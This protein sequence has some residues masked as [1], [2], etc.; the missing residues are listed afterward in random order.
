MLATYLLK[1]IFVRKYLIAGCFL[2]GLTLAA[3]YLLVT[4]PVYRS[5][6]SVVAGVRPPETIGP[7]S[8]AEQLSADYLLTQEDI[9]KSDRVAQEVVKSTRLA[10]APNIAERF[11]WS[12]EFGPLTD[13]I[14]ERLRLGLIVEQ[15]TTNSRVMNVS[16]LSGDPEFSATMANAFAD[17]FIQTNLQL[18]NDPARRNIQS[19]DSQLQNIAIK[20]KAMQAELAKKEKA[21]GIV[22]SKGE[23]DPG[24]TQLSALASN[25]ASAEAN[26]ANAQ[27]A[28]RTGAL[29]SEVSNPVVQDLQV[30]I[31]SKS[32]QLSQLATTLGPN[33]PDYRQV[34]SELATLKS[35]LALQ[36][37][38]VRR[39]TAAAA[40]QATQARGQIAGAVQSQRSQVTATRAAQNE[41]AVL[42][43][44]LANLRASYDQIGQRRAQLEVLD[45]TDQTNISFLSRAVP[46]PEPVAPKETLV[47]L[48]GALG[49]LVL[50]LAIALAHEFSNRRIR[51]SEQLESQL[52]IRD[53]G[54]IRSNV[55]ERISTVRMATAL[56]SAPRKLLSHSQ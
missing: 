56:L 21:L 26:A 48:L 3:I 8:V 32:G 45:H 5:T 24:V 27:A 23:A 44:D 19:Y 17:A 55:G 35:Q 50:G 38:I 52:G 7:L 6:A 37:S 20:M 33:H 43:Q 40:A 11:E 51:L 49:G 16:Y 9:L 15:S 13:Y 1:S 53:L 39:A 41:V 18:Q 42:E 34:A 10:E 36:R 14:A 4:S 25:L 46:N 2:L 30:T 54:S 12:P 29:V 28:S 31:A 47:V 22:S